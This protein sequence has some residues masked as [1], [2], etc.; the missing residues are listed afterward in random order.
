MKKEMPPAAI[1]AVV[2]VL[3]VIIGFIAYKQF[4]GNPAAQ[5][6]SPDQV[7]AVAQMRTNVMAPGVHRD[8]NGHFVDAQGNPINMNAAPASPG[9]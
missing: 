7:K 8:V 4:G 6:A 9:Q 1:A 3:V 5:A 2:V